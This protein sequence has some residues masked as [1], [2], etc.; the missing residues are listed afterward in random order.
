ML[1]S[2]AK[3]A[4]IAMTDPRPWSC[5]PLGVQPS[6]RTFLRTV[7]A[8]A[9][10]AGLGASELVLGQPPPEKVADDEPLPAFPPDGFPPDA[11]R[12]NFNENSLGPSPKALR[13]ILG[14]GLGGASR[15]NFISPL[16]GA[17]AEHHGVDEKNVLVG[18]GSTEFLQFAP[19][20]FFR[21]GGNLVLPSP[22]YG[23]SAGV[24]EGMGR[25]ARRVPVR[26]DGTVD[27]AGLKKAVDRDTRMVYVANPNNP[28]GAALTFEEVSSFLDAIP[29]G[30]VLLV[31]EAYSQFL[32]AG[33]TA[34]DLVRAGAPVMAL[35]TFSKAYGM[36]GLRL[37]YVVAAG[38][39]L[40]KLKSVWWGDFGIN[41]A[42]NVAGP[43]ALA[44]TAHVGR[45]VR[46]VDEGLVQ[47]RTGLGRLG[48]RSMP[49]RAP[50]FMVDLGR[51]AKGVVAA[52][53]QRGVFVRDGSDWDMPSHL[54]VSVGLPDENEALLREL[55]AVTRKAA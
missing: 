18:C 49:H 20:A 41:A 27:L 22:S 44:D 45:Y 54:R 36:A 37:G 55:L 38:P 16:I 53:M 46:L 52:L 1:A 25:E 15:Y 7:A 3:G 14:D 34:V 42:A 4:F 21:D 50:F 39:V 48:F 30:A 12:L 8:A 32:P 10:A 6:R 35:R 2:T 17:I 47:L 40:R 19:W 51:E 43:A 33:K 9:A 5:Y 31:D 11:V 29:K 23:W 24:V 26:D 13:A 28:T